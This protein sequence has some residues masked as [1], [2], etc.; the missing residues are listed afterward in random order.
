[1][2][3]VAILLFVLT[4][5][6]MAVRA[7][8][9]T[10]KDGTVL[11]GKVLM[12][13]S[14]SILFETEDGKQQRIKA[15]E[16]SAY[17]VGSKTDLTTQ[18]TTRTATVL[19][20]PSTQPFVGKAKTLCAAYQDVK[21]R[22]DR[23]LDA[24]NVEFK[25][26]TQLQ[27]EKKLKALIQKASEMKKLCVYSIDDKIS[28]VDVKRRPD[29]SGAA[30]SSNPIVIKGYVKDCVDAIEVYF[31]ND[32]DGVNKI[33]KY[34]F[35]GVV[36]FDIRL[37]IRDGYYDY[38][39]AESDP[40]F[41]SQTL[42]IISKGSVVGLTLR[43]IFKKSTIFVAPL[44]D[45]IAQDDGNKVVDFVDIEADW[46]K[47]L[48]EYVVAK[49]AIEKT[50]IM[51]LMRQKCD[52]YIGQNVKCDVKIEDLH[53]DQ[54]GY[55]AVTGYNHG[56]FYLRY[57]TSDPKFADFKKGQTVTVQGIVTKSN[58][59]FNTLNESIHDLIKNK[60]ITRFVEI[61]LRENK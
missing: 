11:K 28:V 44:E 2:K 26:L 30:N 23:D 20:G 6:M 15:A 54:D 55:Y 38:D 36:S 8:T 12:A 24:Y 25:E 45:D 29:W 52:G 50:A 39:G 5:F 9:V 43:P 19:S 14:S 22:I 27:K 56:C 40:D 3:K 53:R 33:K 60:K 48:D 1:M 4:C 32:L 7:D 21:S 57:T 51:D 37:R 17:S 10:M 13:T 42:D 41:A 18:P 46:V 34:R 35:T 47:M 49:S 31:G 59:A 58:V 61:S 16:F